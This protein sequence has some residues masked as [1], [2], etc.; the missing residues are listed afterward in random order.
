M[1]LQHQRRQQ[2]F[3]DMLE[4]EHRMAQT[5]V[6]QEGEEEDEEGEETDEGEG[7]EEEGEEDEE[8]EVEVD[9]EEETDKGEGEEEE[10]E[11]EVGVEGEENGEEEEGVEGEG[12]DGEDGEE[13]EEGEEEEGDEDDDEDEVRFSGNWGK[14]TGQ[15]VAGFNNR[16]QHS[17]SD[18]CF[19]SALCVISRCGFRLRLSLCYPH[20]LFVVGDCPMFQP[21]CISAPLNI[22]SPHTRV[23]TGKSG[24]LNC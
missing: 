3:E 21:V 1:K 2:E 9:E 22:L 20:L 4:L 7:E 15:L 19:H 14:A 18:H 8:E 13:G 12:E 5:R 6:V 10:D 24:W 11:E 23:C 17:I 16:R